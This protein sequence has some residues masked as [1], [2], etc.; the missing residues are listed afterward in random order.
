MAVPLA[1]KNNLWLKAVAL[2][3]AICTGF[4]CNQ[5]HAAAAEKARKN[6]LGKMGERW[7]DVS[8]RCSRKQTN[9]APEWEV[10]RGSQL[11]LGL[12]EKAET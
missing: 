4:D 1:D 10:G 3:I 2:A 7:E 9:R 6:M 5:P 11:F 12:S 8:D